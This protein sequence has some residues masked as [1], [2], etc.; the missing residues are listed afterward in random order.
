MTY[1]LS[2]KADED[3]ITVYLEGVRKFGVKQAEKYFIELEQTFQLLSGSPR[4]ARERIEIIP[5]VRV[6]TQITYHNLHS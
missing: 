1:S 6:H 5:P 3:I 2:Q 4:L